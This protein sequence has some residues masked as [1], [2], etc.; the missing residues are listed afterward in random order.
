MSALRKKRKRSWFW[1]WK[2]P[3]AV[4]EIVMGRV[5][6]R[7][8]GKARTERQ[9]EEYGDEEKWKHGKSKKEKTSLILP[10]VLLLGIRGNHTM[11]YRFVVGVRASSFFFISMPIPSCSLR[12][13]VTTS[14]AI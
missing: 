12:W 8:G 5:E 13:V 10:V 3:T 11:I 1:C 9:E 4:I 2:K 6:K 14:R 7:R